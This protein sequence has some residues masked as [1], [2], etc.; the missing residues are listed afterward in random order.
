VEQRVNIKFCDKLRKT[1]VETHEMLV[2]VYGA[3]A[4]SRKCVYDR[5]KRFRDG[6][7]TAEREPRAGRSVTAVL[8]LIP[9][10]AFA[11]SFQQLYERC[12]KCVVMNGDYFGD[13]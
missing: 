13:E 2:L 1:A 4:V 9:I 10:R 5:F 12:Q 6:K 11:D 8:R 3:E 7:E